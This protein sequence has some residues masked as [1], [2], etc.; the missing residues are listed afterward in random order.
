MM[1]NPWMI[2]PPAF[3]AFLIP[4]FATLAILDLVVRG[5]A[6]WKAGRNNQPYW[7]VALL[8][9]NTMGILPVIYILFFRKDRV[10][11]PKKPETRRKKK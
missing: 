9:F 1:Y 3:L 4:F 8:I 11:S 10:A 7:F 2:T 5:Y 6:L